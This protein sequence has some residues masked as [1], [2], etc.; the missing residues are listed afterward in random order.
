MN[1]T[2]LGTEDMGIRSPHEHAETLPPIN[3][4]YTSASKFAP[5]QD[6]QIS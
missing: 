1:F 4:G 5:L 2:H 3:S 6:D